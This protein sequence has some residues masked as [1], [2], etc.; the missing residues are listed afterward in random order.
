MD[1]EQLEVKTSFLNDDSKDMEQPEGFEVNGK[2]KLVG[3][4]KKSLYGLKQASRQWYKKFESSKVDNDF[5]K[6]HVDH[7]VFVKN[8]SDG[9]F[10]ILL[11]YV[12]DIL[13]VDHDFNKIAN[14]KACLSKSFAMRPWPCKANSRHVYFS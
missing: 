5:H 13:I 10:L 14:L 2:E 8:F 6:T 12:N 9:D 7:C 11:L 1:I 3:R 4:K